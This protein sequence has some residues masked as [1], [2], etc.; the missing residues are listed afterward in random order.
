MRG[1]R[2]IGCSYLTVAISSP[3]YVYMGAQ[4]DDSRVGHRAA[5]TQSNDSRVG[6]EAAEPDAIGNRGKQWTYPEAMVHS[7]HPLAL[8]LPLE[9]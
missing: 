2:R 9:L 6:R 8:Q 3:L 4:G 1:W 7:V 5:E